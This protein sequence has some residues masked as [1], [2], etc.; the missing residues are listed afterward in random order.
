MVAEIAPWDSPSLAAAEVAPWDSPAP[1]A[2][3]VPRVGWVEENL[4]GPS[5]VLSSA[6]ANIPHAA[7]HAAIDL[8]RRVTG[9]DTSA[10]DPAAVRAI[11]VP[12]A[13]GG[14]QLT[15]DLANDWKSLPRAT[16]PQAPDDTNI[17]QFNAKTE[18]IFNQA[19]SVAGDV[20]NL[21][22]SLG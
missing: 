9:G 5:E 15:S 7:A 19:G 2:D 4:V 13:A 20:A 11:E 1:A 8:Y 18:D 17:P 21:T 10:P 14:R 3:D 16:G 6:V 22:P 12:T